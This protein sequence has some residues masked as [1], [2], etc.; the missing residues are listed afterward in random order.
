MAYN[1]ARYHS[2]DGHLKA[3]WSGIKQR[4]E[5]K[6]YVTSNGSTS[7]SFSRTHQ[8]YIGKTFLSREA[9]IAWSM[10]DEAYNRLHAA[11]EAAGFP[12]HRVSPSI[13]RYPNPDGDYV[14]GNI[15][16]IT[17]SENMS[18]ASRRG[19]EAKRASS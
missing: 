7:R 13:D 10:S 6:P 3:I 2:K 4:C 14:I 12:R 18:N 17:H 19:L 1:S 9:F 5:G 8:K 16:W 11:W 15:R